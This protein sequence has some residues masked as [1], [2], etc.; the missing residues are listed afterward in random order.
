MVSNKLLPIV[1]IGLAVLGAPSWAQTITKDRSDTTVSSHKEGQWRS[2]KVIGLN[3]YNDAKEKVGEVEEIIIDKSGRVSD[4]ILGVGGFLGMGEHYVAV[5][6]DKLTW[7]NEPVRSTST[8]TIST[9]PV[10]TPT[11]GTTDKGAVTGEVNRSNR[12]MRA[13]NEIWY[14]DHAVYNVSKD[15]L[16]KMPQF[17]YN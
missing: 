11:V 1:F 14:P 6:M 15:E 17:K 10:N 4:V 12:P 8:T 13:G 3:V 2:S 5:S 7:I 16:K 9:A